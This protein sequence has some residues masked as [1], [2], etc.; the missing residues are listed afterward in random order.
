MSWW[1]CNAG[2]NNKHP[3]FPPLMSDGRNYAS[4]Q[5]GAEINERLRESAGIK[6]NS[7]YRKYLIDNADEIAQTNQIYAC[8]RCCTSNQCK[9]HS[10]LDSQPAVPF[11]YSSCEETAQ[12]FGYEN[13]DMKTKYLTEYQLQSRLSTPVITQAQLIQRKFPNWN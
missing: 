13:S 4:W 8:D 6:S 3:D 7:A 10:L 5:P 2:S 9:T 1:N 11:M 12:P